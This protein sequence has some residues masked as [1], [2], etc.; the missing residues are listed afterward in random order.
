MT[1]IKPGKKA[2]K[3][4]KIKAT[5]VIKARTILI[6]VKTDINDSTPVIKEIMLI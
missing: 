4:Q 5:L 1:V 3:G 6:R 2:Y